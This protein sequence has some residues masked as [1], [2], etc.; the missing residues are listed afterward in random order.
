MEIRE[1]TLKSL[2]QQTANL[3]ADHKGENTTLIDVSGVSS[4]TSFFIIT[5]VMS[6]GHL[7]GLVR[8]LRHFLSGRQVEIQHKHR[9]IDTNGWELLDCGEMVIHLM[10]SDMREFYDLEML[11]QSGEQLPFNGE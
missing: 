4:W 7:R 9:K 1:D 3:L 10:S 8:E 11:W 5:T 2:A 6:A